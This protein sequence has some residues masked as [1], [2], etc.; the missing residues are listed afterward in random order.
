M[1]EDEA[2]PGSATLEVMSEAR[3]YNQFLL[4]WLEGAIQAGDRVLDFGAGTGTFALPLLQRG[5]DLICLEPDA[6]LGARLRRSGVRTIGELDEVSDSSIDLIYTLNVLEHIDDDRAAVATLARKLRPG[7]RILI[8]VPAFQILYSPFDRKIGHR[9]RYRRGALMR[10]AGEAG[11]A[12]RKAEY[13]DSLGFGA[14]LAYRVVG[15][16][17]GELDPASV[18]FFDRWLFPLSRALD[19]VLWPWLGK[20]VRLIAERP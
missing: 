7:G 4:S 10:L 8:Y 19:R 14:A 1:I 2:Y 16:A 6:G 20:N 17:T 9:R 3:N 15:S 13:V 18:R 5:V 12:V 11:L